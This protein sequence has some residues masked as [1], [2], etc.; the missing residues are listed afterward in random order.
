MWSNFTDPAIARIAE[1]AGYDWVI[2]D[3]EHNP[4]TKS[5]VQ[6]LLPSLKEDDGT[7]IPGFL[8]A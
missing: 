7:P 1:I 5:P 3:T 6:A 4:F 2:I 8:T